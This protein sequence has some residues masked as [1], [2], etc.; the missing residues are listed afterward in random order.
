MKLFNKEIEKRLPALYSSEEIPIGQKTIIC[1]FFA[2]GSNYTWYAIEGERQENGDYLFF[3]L[4]DGIE[5]E[6]GYFTLSQ[7]ENLMW[8]GIPRVER[9]L[10]FKSVKVVDVCNKNNIVDVIEE[11]CPF[12]DTE[13]TMLNIFIPQPC[14]NCSEL[15]LPCSICDARNCMECSL[16]SERN[17]MKER[18]K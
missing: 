4:I 13:S 5:L 8:N 7:L 10:H 1:K 9:D 14:S 17:K 16:E 3:G 6:L 11:Y 2:L 18:Q 15:L 12:C